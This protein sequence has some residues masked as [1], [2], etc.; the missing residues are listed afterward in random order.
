MN[1]YSWNSRRKSWRKLILKIFTPSGFPGEY[2]FRE[3]KNN[4]G[5]HQAIRNLSSSRSP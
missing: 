1:E 4:T 2:S 5:K 3:I